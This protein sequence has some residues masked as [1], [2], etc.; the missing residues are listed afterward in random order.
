MQTFRARPPIGFCSEFLNRKGK[1]QCLNDA[2]TRDFIKRLNK[3]FL[4]IVKILRI[5]RGEKQEIE[6]LI[7]EEALLFAMY[8][9][10]QRRT[11]NPRIVNLT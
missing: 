6:T 5:M 7:K 2:K 1:R 9:R 11:W 8:L 3:Y 10:N 4:T